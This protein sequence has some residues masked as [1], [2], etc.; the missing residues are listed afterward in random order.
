MARAQLQPWDRG[1]A[2]PEPCGIHRDHR[3][4][5]LAYH[6]GEVWEYSDWGFDTLGRVV[7]VASGEPLDQFFENHIFKPLG[8]VDSGFYVP[9]AKLPRLVDPAPEGR[10]GLFDVTK[11]AKYLSGAGGLVST[12]PDICASARC[13]SMAA[14][15]TACAFSKLRPLRR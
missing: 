1:E 13:C 6:P 15:S 10:A 12:A 5:P 14:S 8:M 4:A 11:P 3:H 9:E 2:R 7:E